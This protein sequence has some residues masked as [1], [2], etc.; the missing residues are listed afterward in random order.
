[1]LLSEGRGIVFR[2]TRLYPVGRVHPTAD[3][4]L[5]GEFQQTM[6]NLFRRTPF[7]VATLVGLGLATALG[8]ALLWWTK[9][10]R[11]PLRVIRTLPYHEA[12]AA[13]SGLSQSLLD[14]ESARP[15]EPVQIQRG[16]TLSGLLREFGLE[17]RDANAAVA[18]LGE[19]VEVRRIRAGE[20]GEVWFDP[21]GQLMAFE[22]QL[23]GRGRVA[24]HREGESWRS[25]WMEFVR[26]ETLKQTAGELT[27]T[28]E[29]SVRRGEGR[30]QLAYAMS[31]VLQ[32][33]LDFNRDLRRGDTFQALYKEVY[34]DGEF[35]EVG[36]VLALV[37]E[38]QGRKLEAY[39]YG[40][41]GYY[42]AEGRPLQKMFLRSPLPF[43]RVTSRFSKRRFHPVLKTYRPHY[44]V[45]YGAPKGTAVRATSHGVAD[46]VGRNGGA[47]K[48]VRLRHSN[49]YETSYLHLS[50]YASGLRRGR[51]VSQGEVIGY[52]GSTGLSTGPHL[53]YR[54]KKNGR[55]LDPLTLQ[56]TP[57]RPIPQQ[58]L[59]AFF[60]R[61][62]ALRAALGGAPLQPELPPVQI[63]AQQEAAEA[64]DE[65]QGAR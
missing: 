14:L 16:Q 33:D 34:L 6:T 27:D 59:Q 44:G 45:D 36:E 39:R 1:M 3:T 32:W 65:I 49:G 23:S 12:A 10:A 35:T 38:N 64:P 31:R 24:L 48:M 4:H 9:D 22:L 53:D 61:R 46:F 50:G 18:A 58:G 15:P 21:Q 20:T 41:E 17:P 55:W 11:S 26:T 13:R 5:I 43:T 62:D 25:S 28:L 52:V 51:R 54:V 47:G 63:V 37:Y 7:R 2:P 19:Y 60:R 29:A 57:A 42:D 30:P 8:L 56:N 40:E